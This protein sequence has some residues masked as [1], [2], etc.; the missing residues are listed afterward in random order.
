VPTTVP[1]KKAPGDRWSPDACNFLN[2]TTFRER[3]TGLEPVTSSLGR[4]PV[5]GLQL[6]YRTVL[7]AWTSRTPDYGTVDPFWKT[8]LVDP[9][10]TPAIPPHRER[11]RLATVTV[12]H[13]P[14][15]RTPNMAGC[16]DKTCP[17]SYLRF[18]AEKR[19]HTSGSKCA[20]HSSCDMIIEYG[21]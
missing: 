11:S 10:W 8:D 20:A 19:F 21:A 17:G 1:K 2:S 13:V 6:R 3:A 9:R 12:S 14:P 7:W 18:A 5:Y 4:R 16:G 15:A